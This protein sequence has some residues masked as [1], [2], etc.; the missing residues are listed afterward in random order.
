MK[1]LKKAIPVDAWQVPQ[2]D[3]TSPMPPQWVLDFVSDRVI[4]T[5]PDHSGLLV[6][7]D[8]TWLK[9]SPGDW[10]LKDAMGMPYP[11]KAEVFALTYEPFIEGEK[12]A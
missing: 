1:Y 4:D 7:V 6:R 2:P 12:L 5:A 8:G 3:H 10:I 11:C 9:A